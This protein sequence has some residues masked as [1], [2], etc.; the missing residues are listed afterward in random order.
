MAQEL[1]VTSVTV[2]DLLDKLRAREWMIPAFQ[3]DFVWAIGDVSALVYSI[4]ERRPIGMATLWRQPDDSELHLEP[5]SIR[6]RDKPIQLSGAQNPPAMKYA[7]LDGRQRCTA[8]AIAFGGLRP[9]D[10]R[11]RFW[12]RYFLNLAEKEDSKRI[13]FIR[14]AD[15]IKR[16]LNSDSAA[17]GTGLFP[18]SSS[19]QDESLMQQWYRYTQAIQDSA[20]YPD[21]ILP[22]PDELDRRNRILARS[23]EGL[24]ATKL[25]VNIVPAS[26]SLPEICEI[27]EVL[28]TTG[29]KVS[30]VDLIHSWLFSETSAEEAPI[31]LREWLDRIGEL[32]GAV[33]WSS[34]TDRP[35][36]IA[37][38]TTATYVSLESRPEPRAVGHTQQT[39]VASVRSGDL[40]ATPTLHWK[41]VMS[42]QHE[43]VDFLGDFQQCVAHGAF[44]WQACPYPA[45]ASVYV[46]L[47]WHHRFDVGITHPWEISDLDALFR[48]FFWRN[49]LSS[50]YDQ[51]FLTQLGTDITQLKSILK[52]RSSFK[53]FDDW[54]SAAD[55]KLVAFM[56]KPVPDSTEL[57][58][59]FC[60]RQTGALQKALLLPI[61]ARADR[62]L[63]LPDIDISFPTRTDIQ[64]HHIYP[65]A[66]CRNN[67]TAELRKWLDP[68]VSEKDWVGSAANLMPMTR[69]SNLK[70]RAANPGAI[71][72]QQ[73]L[74]FNSRAQVFSRLFIAEEA[75]QHLENGIDGI[76]YFWAARANA[77]ADHLRQLLT[78]ANQP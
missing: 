22:E 31:L 72:H 65:Q 63:L 46:G 10:G 68:D 44:G 24:M 39:K 21:S 2:S 9:T 20:N 78:V 26:Y 27:F 53:R 29:T 45:T 49:A 36:L 7:V 61:V 67:R 57:H 41:N 4:L 75:F 19:N 42:H 66:W 30:T 43:L 37:Q 77:L 71:I 48:A 38:M 58:D 23:F 8:I 55:K 12:G 6:D 56:N 34:S 11:V 28:N 52:E 73:S 51:G 54:A 13:E 17:I 50:R 1:E 5:V 25:A 15:L 33:G 64:L 60:G 62:D 3:R 69:E 16:G 18:L 74:T 32:S 35:E 76:P 70:W 59:L 40:L 47:R 14:E